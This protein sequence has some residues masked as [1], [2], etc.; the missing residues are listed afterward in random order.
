M[1]MVPRTP[2]PKIYSEKQ[3]IID[4]RLAGHPQ[5]G[6][7]AL[8]RFKKPTQAPLVLLQT[9]SRYPPE[10]PGSFGGFIGCVQLNGLL[11]G[12]LRVNSGGLSCEF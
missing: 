6:A 1:A 10:F 5:R 7:T 3:Q 2:S 12:G 8:T 4:L 9:E 11:L